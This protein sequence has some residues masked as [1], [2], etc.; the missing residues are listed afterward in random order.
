MD[1]CS[2]CGKNVFFGATFKS[3]IFCKECSKIINIQN[4]I[5]RNFITL[6]NLFEHQRYALTQARTNNFPKNIIDEIDDYFREY[7]K[8]EFICTIDGKIGQKLKLFGDY[9]I[10]NTKDADTKEELIDSIEDI[11][12][13]E[14]EDDDEDVFSVEDKLMMAKSLMKGGILTTGIKVAASSGL[15]QSAKEQKIS[16]KR[17]T[18]RKQ[19][20]KSIKVGDKKIYY[21]DIRN[22]EIICKKSESIGYMI[23]ET[24]IKNESSGNKKEYFLYNN[25]SFQN[26]NIKNRVQGAKSTIEFKINQELEKNTKNE[27]QHEN[28]PQEENIFKKIK[29]AK[30]MYDAGIIDENEFKEIKSKLIKDM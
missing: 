5:D 18:T 30:E 29:E 4:W 3:N 9:I 10:I 14:D 12:D 25:G 13:T 8:K 6:Q 2:V 28:T 16:N 26:S 19:M 11:D 27:V 21:K 22:V 7:V 23:L 1:K 24:N 20:E 15:K 17:K